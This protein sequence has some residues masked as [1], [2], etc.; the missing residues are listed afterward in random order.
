MT[1]EFEKGLLDLGG[2]AQV[3]LSGSE[4][5]GLA[6]AGLV[7]GRGESMVIDTLY[8][9]QHAQEMVD[10]IGGVTATSPVRYI[11][12]THSDGDHIFGNQLFS[13]AEVVATEAASTQMTQE[14]ADL[15]AALFDES[16]RPE[17]VLHPVAA[18]TQEF[19]IHP[20]RVRAADTTFR[21][22]K[23]IRVGG[24]EVQMHELGPAHTVGD[25]IAYLPAQKV[26]FAGDLLT[27]DIVKVTWSGSIPNWITALDRIRAF[28]A[29]T[30]VAGHGPVLTGEAITAAIDLATE[31]WSYIHEQAQAFYD[32]GV[33]A[34]EA[35]ARIDVSKYP[36]ANVTLPILVTAVY[37][38]CNP[39]IPYRDVTQAFE[40]MAGQVAKM[41]APPAEPQ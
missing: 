22:E 23:E 6:N 13:D 4:A 25:A 41:M 15:T 36:L 12:N 7:V 37:H 18:L 35:A 32:L 38:E 3:F 10:A 11:F 31:F 30:V 14:H 33:P 20:V 8:D 24:V 9:V 28:G 5:F 26:L 2:G 16:R 34:D 1:F 21:G 40:S 27:R 19:D 17:S 39:E 29:E